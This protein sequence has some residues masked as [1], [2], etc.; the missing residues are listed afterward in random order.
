MMSESESM[1]PTPEQIFVRNLNALR[2]QRDLSIT[3]LAE[4]C[5]M[6]REAMSRLLNEKQPPNLQTLTQIADG[7]KVP[8]HKLLDPA[9]S[10][11]LLVPC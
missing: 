7:V 1:K 10:E 8:L 5:G 2:E 3:D 11:N 9:F 6:V 4:Q